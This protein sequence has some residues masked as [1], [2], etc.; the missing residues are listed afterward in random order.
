MSHTEWQFATDKELEHSLNFA[1]A[2][3]ER[4]LSEQH[5]EHYSQQVYAILTEKRLR[6]MVKERER[7]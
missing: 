2:H 5:V 3:V 4:A 1:R 6:N 7:N